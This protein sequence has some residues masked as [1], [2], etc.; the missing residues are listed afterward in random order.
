MRRV[1]F[2]SMALGVALSFVA[3]CIPSGPN[4][5]SG[6]EAQPAGPGASAPQG[7]I[8]AADAQPAK[9]APELLQEWNTLAE[10]G[11]THL[12]NPRPREIGMELKK[13]G[14]EHLT[15][16]LDV[17]GDPN[18]K[19]G[20]KALAMISLRAVA[21]PDM[22]ERLKA[23][24]KPDQDGTMRAC[25]ADLLSHIPNADTM[26]F[27]KTLTND[28]E[29]RVRVASLIGLV[30]NG[31]ADSRKGLI[32]LYREADTNPRQ[33][34]AIILTVTDTA[35]V[36]DLPALSEAVADAALDVDTRK[37]VAL[38]LGRIGDESVVEALT[39][40]TDAPAPEALRGVATDAVTVIRSRAKDTEAK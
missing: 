28:P 6:N 30:G 21:T 23:M 10:A 14:P 33:K 36:A 31:D 37:R 35:S 40:C 12:S 5:K 25:A 8:Q 29:K 24:C 27:L 9:S 17:L 11:E 13:L 20:A 34:A 26:A 19:P 38:V 7:E 4:A 32:E 39:K 22:A 2:R 18:S 16:I 1:S 15:P 3:A